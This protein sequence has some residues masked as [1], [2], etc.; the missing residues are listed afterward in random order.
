MLKVYQMMLP[1][2]AMYYTANI[3]LVKKKKK[4][5]GG[6]YLKCNTFPFI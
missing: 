6:I 2:Y 1:K 4:K 3:L 5:P